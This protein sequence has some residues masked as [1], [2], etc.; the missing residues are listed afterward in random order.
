MHIDKAVFAF[1]FLS[2]LISCNT[3]K[4]PPFGKRSPHEKYAEAITSAGLEESALGRAWFNAADK[5]LTQ[6]QTVTLPYTE[7][8][9]F[10]ADEPSAAGFCFNVARGENIV[11][12]LSSNPDSMQVFVELWQP[13][14][15]KPSLRTAMDTLSKILKFTVTKND[16]FIVRIQ[17]ELLVDLEYTITITTQP[18]LAFPVDKSG[19]PRLLSFW[20]N[21]RDNGLRNHEG[22]DI[23]AKF[24][25][26]ALA[27]AD[28]I[29][30]R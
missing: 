7:T 3:I 14:N 19:N 28:G 8:G 6:P 29:I 24:R 5:A 1:C 25:T 18:S 17:P 12:T 26:P 21:E 30:S 11:V 15:Q 2:I 10:A 23:G 20:G 9:F 27:A 22:V 4:S 13:G 16:S